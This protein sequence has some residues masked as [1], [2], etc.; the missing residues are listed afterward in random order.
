MQL[1]F[2]EDNFSP[3]TGNISYRKQE[4][5]INTCLYIYNNSSEKRVYNNIYKITFI[6]TTV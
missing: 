1:N 5:K 3:Y 6:Y 4:V 2:E